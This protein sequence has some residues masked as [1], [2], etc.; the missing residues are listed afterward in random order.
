VA[1]AFEGE[2]AM[3]AAFRQVSP[4]AGV[5]EMIPSGGAGIVVPWSEDRRKRSNAVLLVGGAGLH[6]ASNLRHAVEAEE[7][8]DPQQLM[9]LASE[10]QLV[11]GGAGLSYSVSLELLKARAYRLYKVTANEVP[12][13][14]VAKVQAT[15]PRSSRV[16]ATLK[17]LVLREKLVKIAIRPVQVLDGRGTKVLFTARF[18]PPERLLDK[19][20]AIWTPQANVVFSLGRTDPALIDGLT[21]NSDGADIQSPTTRPGF[22]SNKDKAAAVTAFLVRT[23]Y[24]GAVGAVRGVVDPE[25]G[26]MLISDGRGETTLAHEAG[27]FLGS[28][29]EHGKFSLRYGHPGGQDPVLLMRDGGAGWKIPFSQ[30]T[31]FN[32]GYRRH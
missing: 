14:D 20:N 12:G 13:L 31:D 7:I 18:E 9:A 11:Y 23:A 5:D 6:V 24:D 21:P 3:P 17:V 28:L 10:L 29:D 32:K 25:A 22:L 27:H 26:F 16:E 30:V 15:N 1:F 2:I 4:F 8:T 19:M